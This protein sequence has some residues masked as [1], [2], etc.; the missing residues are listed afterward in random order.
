MPA[1]CCRGSLPSRSALEPSEALRDED[2]AV[3]LDKRECYGACMQVGHVGAHV[4][5]HVGPC[6]RPAAVHECCSGTRV[7]Q[8]CCW[9]ARL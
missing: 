8:C 2:L 3:A 9:H 5:G 1:C 7:Q 4:G 6:G